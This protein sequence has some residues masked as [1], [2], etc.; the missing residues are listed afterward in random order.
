MCVLNVA[1]NFLIIFVC[2]KD[3]ELG[4]SNRLFQ[5]IIRNKFEFGSVIKMLKI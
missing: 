2:D 3:G 4:V 1:T 5:G